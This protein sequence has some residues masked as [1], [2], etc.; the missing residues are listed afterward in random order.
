MKHNSKCIRN[1][2]V[3]GKNIQSRANCMRKTDFSK[4]YGT[5]KGGIGGGKR[6]SIRKSPFAF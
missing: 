1:K 2:N 3:S 6:W 5:E 4:Y